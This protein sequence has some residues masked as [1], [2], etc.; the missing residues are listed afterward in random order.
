MCVRPSATRGFRAAF[1]RAA[2]FALVTVFLGMALL[3]P[4]SRTH[5]VRR[6][7]HVIE[8]VLRPLHLFSPWRMFVGRARFGAVQI[9]GVLA[10]GSQTPIASF[11]HE[12]KTLLER[13]RDGRMR[14]LHAKLKRK[15]AWRASYMRYLCRNGRREH[16]DLQALRVMLSKPQ[17]RDDE[18]SIVSGSER[19]VLH[20]H[21]CG[22]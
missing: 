10:D 17:I 21:V 1:G 7:V 5:A 20:E 22:T 3:Q 2:A 6:K 11:R 13:I 18:G 4:V 9:D 12:G 19:R 8:A 15:R 14:K 16:P